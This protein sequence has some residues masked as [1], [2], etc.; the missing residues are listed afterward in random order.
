MAKLLGSNNLLGSTKNTNENIEG[1][2]GCHY[3]TADQ[4][5]DETVAAHAIIFFKLPDWR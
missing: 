5:C 3:D 1:H 2:I 4:P